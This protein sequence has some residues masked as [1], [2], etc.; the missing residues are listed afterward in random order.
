[1]PELP[2]V[3]VARLGI[4][5]HLLNQEIVGAE[6]RAARLRHA[7]D[8]ALGQTLAGLRVD[9]IER[10]GKYLLFHCHG[11]QRA[12]C[13]ILHLGMSGSL[14]WIAAAELGQTPPQRHDHVDLVFASGRLRYRDPRRFGT[15]LWHPG[16][17]VLAH[18]LLAPLGIEPLNF[19]AAGCTRRFAAGRRRSN[20][21]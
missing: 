7:L 1:M 3:E 11:G 5:P 13:L 10:R 20:R 18:P 14:R 15:L 16:D 21:C 9:R 4:A 19:A 12:G 17:D 2:E 8:A 6:V